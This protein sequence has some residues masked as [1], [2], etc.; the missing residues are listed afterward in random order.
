MEMILNDVTLSDVAVSLVKI[1]HA[2]CPP[3]HNFVC[4]MPPFRLDN[5]P[6]S[7]VRVS[8][9]ACAPQ[10]FNASYGP[11]IDLVQAVA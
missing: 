7:L 3:F 8:L 9:N 5:C 6:I 11:D 2:Y 10:T 4:N 1:M